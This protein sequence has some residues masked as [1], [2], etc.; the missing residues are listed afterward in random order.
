V[1]HD[2]SL[3]RSNVVRLACELGGDACS[4][5]GACR[6]NSFPASLSFSNRTF[7][8]TVIRHPVDRIFSYIHFTVGERFIL[9]HSP[10]MSALERSARGAAG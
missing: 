7:L 6:C 2:S 10:V 5:V 4:L 3:C 9:G 8:M 1:L